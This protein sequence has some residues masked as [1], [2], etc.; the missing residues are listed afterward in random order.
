[1][2]ITEAECSAFDEPTWP[3]FRHLGSFPLL[4]NDEAAT[5]IISR[6]FQNQF[7]ADFDMDAAP[8]QAVRI[9]QTRS[10]HYR[11]SAPWNCGGIDNDTVDT[12]DTP[13]ANDQIADISGAVA[14]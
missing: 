7:A 2:R 10:F 14:I 3:V 9:L 6:V 12:W 8:L 11:L 5:D 1:M 13:A 4:Y